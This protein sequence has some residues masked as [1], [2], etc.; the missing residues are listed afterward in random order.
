MVT[1]K[2]ADL[3]SAK[4]MVERQQRKFIQVPNPETIAGRS[5]IRL[6]KKLRSEESRLSILKRSVAIEEDRLKALKA[7]T[8][9]IE[10]TQVEERRKEPDRV[11][12]QELAD[13]YKPIVIECDPLLPSAVALANPLKDSSI[14][15]FAVE[16]T[17]NN[18][19]TREVWEKTPIVWTG[20]SFTQVFNR[21]R[22]E[23]KYQED[24]EV[25]SKAVRRKVLL[26]CFGKSE[27]VMNLSTVDI[28]RVT[29]CYRALFYAIRVDSS[30]PL[31][32]V[33][34]INDLFVSSNPNFDR[35]LL[36]PTSAPG[37]YE[38]TSRP[39]LD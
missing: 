35:R 2:Q 14:G 7:E 29:F 11:K 18:G 9:A 15:R 34:L 16:S 33:K 26:L 38:K 12:A 27:G 13:L 10:E 37:P 31:K 30:I 1:R 25:F 20:L 23:S 17:V 5:E 3:L 28:H 39:I 8:I 19:L 22:K 36:I 6:Q 32:K 4:F 24:S 21:I